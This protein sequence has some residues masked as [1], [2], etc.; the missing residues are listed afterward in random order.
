MN[1]TILTTKPHYPILDGLRGV[2]AIVVVAF[3]LCEAHATG[4]L[5]QLINH[6]YLAVDFF[7]VLSGFVIGYA[8][9]DRWGKMS[10]GDFCKRRLAR[11]HPMIVVGMAVGAACF[12]LQDSALWP[13]IHGVPLWQMLGIML[14]GMTLLPVP[15]AMDIRGWDEMHPLDGPAW[16]LFFEYFANIL[17]AVVVRKF[18]KTALAVLV[19]VAGAALVHLAVTSPQGDIVGGW[20]LAPAQLRI[21]LTR[22]MYPFFA[23]LLLSRVAQ[24]GRVRNAFG[25]CS[26]LI[27]ALLAMPR[28]GGSERLWANGLYDA[29]AITLMFPLIVYLGASGEVRGKY[30]S[31]LCKLLGGISYPLYITHYPL[32]YVYTGW[33]A[34]A[35]IALAA[36]WPVALLTLAASVALAYASLKLYDEPVRRWLG[37]RWVR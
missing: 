31:R 25:W 28:V 14:I 34:D 15:P 20:S 18:S 10:V 37:R 6:G 4:H 23:G 1:K 2:A 19:A 12:Y 3:H 21:G 17:Y 33:V 29:L 24:P 7:F 22:L 32:I 16:T 35:N 13:T 8:Y 36:A 11:L 27:V 9:D 26:L 5:D 30:S